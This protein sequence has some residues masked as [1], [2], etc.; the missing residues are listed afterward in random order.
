MRN[1]GWLII[2]LA[3]EIYNQPTT[4]PISY[5]LFPIYKNCVM[6]N[7]QIYSQNYG[8]E[9]TNEA[10][11]RFS[12]YSDFLLEYNK[13]VNLTAIKEPDEVEIKHFLDSIVPLSLVQIPEN[14]KIADVGTGPGFPAIPML[15]MRNDLKF[16]LIEATGKKLTFIEQL[17]LKLNLS[18]ELLHKRGE[19]A[20][21]EP[22]YREKFDFVTA[23]AVADL[24]ELA[25]YC[26]PLVKKGGKMLA[27]KGNI[28]DEE[29]CGSRQMIRNLGGKIT[30]I[31]KY[32]LPE[33]NG[34]SLVIIEKTGATPKEYPR[35]TAKIK[36]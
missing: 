9:L 24:K 23:R 17:L 13:K 32:S 36:K 2:E 10:I 29:L 12:L 19:E 5:H 7:L 6:N 28:T 33:N 14:A 11:S 8:L 16:T 3:A 25:E 1:C 4:F 35:P 26:L 34:R 15:I 27:L 20:G 30:E 31:K 21:R 22:L 18:A